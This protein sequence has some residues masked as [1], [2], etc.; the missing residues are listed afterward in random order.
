M[1]TT[2]VY[3]TNEIP[4]YQT[5]YLKDLFASARDVVGNV[6]PIPDYQDYIAGLSPTQ[7]SAMQLGRDSV[8]SYA[9]MMQAGADTLSGGIGAFGEAMDLS[10]MGATNLQGVGAA[11][12]P[13]SYGDFMNPYMDEVVARSDADINRQSDMERNR[14]NASA[15]QAGAFGGSRQ[16]VAEQELARNT[17][18]L[19]SRTGSGLRAQG[20]QTAQDM[21]Q[22]AFENRM[23]RTMTA[24][25]IF[26]QLSQG[27]GALGA[28][29]GG[30]GMD[31]AAMG[32]A[33]QIA[34]QRDINALLG[35][36]SLEQGAEQ[37]RLAAQLQTSEQIRTQ[38]YQDVGFLSDIFQGVP[39]TQNT[40]TASTAP[41]P[42][43]ISQLGG[44]A[45]GI[46]SLYSAD[47]I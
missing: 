34:G 14:I 8:G 26:A 22:K 24:S 18:D 39:S 16:A 44:M 6:G 42:S 43:I 20:Y 47:R 29:I 3:T 35:I 17:A 10:R 13:S 7:L 31:Q 25:Q 32:E 28:G 27:V 5:T 2:T 19:A 9:P 11:Y 33:G 36:G 37:A 12:D 38:P 1:V 30:L 15:V 41:D 23:G 4:E 21:A 46:S 40:M 45:M